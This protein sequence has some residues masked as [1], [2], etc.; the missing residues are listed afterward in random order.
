MT[1]YAYAL[2]E[3]AIKDN[4]LSPNSDQYFEY[5]DKGMRSRFNDYGWEDNASEDVSVNGQAAPATTSQPSSVVAPSARNN[6]ARP[7]KVKLTPTQRALA[8][9]I[10]LTQEQ[11]ANQILKEREMSHG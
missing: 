2:H 3:E 8:K 6:G 10:G 7:R 11:L 9:R 5:I 1:A 4:G